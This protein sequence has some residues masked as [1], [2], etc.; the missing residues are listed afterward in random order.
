MSTVKEIEGAVSSLSR[1]DLA[2]FRT[3]FTQF[4]S[5]AW[6]REMEEDARSGKLDELV[7]RMEAENAGEQAVSLNDFL[8]K[9]ELS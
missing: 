9:E 4:D 6:D 1:A 3:W 5:D 8:D 7:R 2:K